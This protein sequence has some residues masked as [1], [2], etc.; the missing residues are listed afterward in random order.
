MKGRTRS[1]DEAK[2]MY[3]FIEDNGLSEKYDRI[4]DNV[5]CSIKKEFIV[6]PVENV[7]ILMYGF[8]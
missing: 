8:N 3:F 2:C 6:K 4:S 7:F 1:F 5:S